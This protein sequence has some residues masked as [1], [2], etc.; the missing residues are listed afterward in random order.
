VLAVLWGGLVLTLSQSSFAGLLA[1]LFV[2]AALRYPLAK[3]APAVL[4]AAA[5]AVPAVAVAGRPGTAPAVPA[6]TAG[7][8]ADRRCTFPGEEPAPRSDRLPAQ[9]DVPGSLGGDAEVVDAVLR[10]G[11]S[12]LRA[13]DPE[14]RL[15]PATARVRLAER[16]EDQVV[17]LVSA[18]G[19]GRRLL[20]DMWVWG[21]GADRLV[22]TSAGLARGV[23]DPVPTAYALNDALV[24]AIEVCGS[25]YAVLAAAPGTTGRVSWT[26][27]IT[28]QLRGERRSIPAPLRAD[29]TAVFRLD[30]ADARFRLTRA[31]RELWDG[32]PQVGS[33]S[34]WPLPTDEELDR[35]AAA[36]P[37]DG[38]P[39]LLRTI[40]RMSLNGGN[41]PVPQSDRRVL[42]SGRAGRATVAV[43]ACTLP[44]GVQYLTGGSTAAADRL[45]GPYYFGL[46]APG[47]LERTVLAWRPARPG[48]PLVVFAV[49]G[50][51]AEAV[52]AG[53]AVVPVALSGGGGVLA[54]GGSVVRV[55]VYGADDR[56]IG[57]QVP[58]Q[59]LAPV[60]RE[61]PL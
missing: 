55:R 27:A 47:A 4:A 61:A 40:A 59:G 7:A 39:E 52:L 6:P 26:T 46:V 15:D 56:L 43:A 28:P 18:S 12:A 37:G 23:V 22:A 19:L 10:A 29:G 38:D 44:G 24:Q 48:K 54:A 9:R 14:A 30:A 51:R 1:G 17:A 35:V 31:G 3:V 45:D 5:V 8:P 25:S 49:G 42:W 57:E 36:A 2:L 50:V 53:G 60:P 11:W 13:E 16:V 34:P 20:A 58:G 32:G 21:P 33:L 41:I